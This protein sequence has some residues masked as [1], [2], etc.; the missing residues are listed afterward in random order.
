M[1][2]RLIRDLPIRQKLVAILLLT[3]AA[4]LLLSG[5]GIV[6]LDS[7]LF[8]ASMRRDLTALAQI[9]AGNS[10]AA[11]AFE[12]PRVASE[13]LT[14]L[15]VRQHLVGACIYRDD[16][17]QFARYIRE[18]A[19]EQCPPPAPGDVVRFTSKFV[20]VSRGI[21]LQGRRIGTLVL[22]YDLGELTERVQLYGETVIVILL[23]AGLIALLISSR[24]RELIA[25]P[26]SSLARAAQSV[27]ETQDYSVRAKKYARDELGL[28]VDAFNDMLGRIQFR[29][30]EL[31]QALANLKAT[32]QDLARTNEDLER[33]AFVASH[34]LQEPLRMITTYTQLLLKTHPAEFDSD[35]TL[36]VE[37]I[38]QGTKRMRE[39]LID[40]LNYTEIRSHSDEPVAPVDLQMVLQKVLDNL[41]GVIDANRAVITSDPLPRVAGA[42][43]HFIPLFQN[44]I[45]NAIKYRGSDPPRIHI[46]VKDSPEEFRFAVS[47]NGIGIDPEYHE[48][49]FEVFRRLHGKK[50]PGTGIGLSICQ[51]VVERYGGRIWVE[52]QTGRGATFIFT[53][54]HATPQVSAPQVSRSTG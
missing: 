34:D 15:R 38:V 30:E 5:I 16:G 50:I 36:F 8:R 26:V 43:G 47:D 42:E 37:N 4:A 23:A 24:L 22:L 32:N 21:M 35:S 40:L 17:T 39:L 14:A 20:T 53:L 13:T 49:I 41:K 29:D 33:F 52:S 1:P 46:S 9:V 7:F 2:L 18:G 3:S 51:R 12:D 27:S 6:A 19:A 48:R 25:T 54:P 44:L 31:K 45:G 28:L 10:T 11:L